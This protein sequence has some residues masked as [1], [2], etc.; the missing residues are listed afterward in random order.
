[1]KTIIIKSEY[2]E[3]QGWPES[4]KGALRLV[5]KETA[6][7]YRISQQGERALRR[8]PKDQVSEVSY[9]QEAEEIVLPTNIS[10]LLDAASRLYGTDFFKPF[11]LPNKQFVVESTSNRTLRD[12]EVEVTHQF[13]EIEHKGST[14]E[15]PV[16]CCIPI[17]PQPMGE[18]DV[19]KFVRKF[20]LEKFQE[21]MGNLSQ[22]VKVK[23]DGM[24]VTRESFSGEQRFTVREKISRSAKITLVS[25]FGEHMEAPQL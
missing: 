6:T 9:G 20:G 18:Q 19:D 17:P 12:G 13:Y 16:W 11:L 23:P 5:R 10:G 22:I 21:V 1:M 25:K 3:Q 24:F 2:I 8:V 15:L 14:Y 4:L 7:E